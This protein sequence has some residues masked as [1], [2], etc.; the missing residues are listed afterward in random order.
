MKK[1][2]TLALLLGSS[3]FASSLLSGFISSAHAT[4]ATNQAQT[5]ETN[6]QTATFAIEKMTCQMCPI[7]I[8][9]AIEKV[10]GVIK[11][12]VDYD[13]K[14]AT[15]IFDPTKTNTNVIALASTNAGYP[16]TS[17]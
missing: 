10:D 9:K 6:E 7:T 14:T 17:I 8:R 3:L 16:A 12:T 11:A 1:L 2:T 13:T 15:V 5:A 4:A